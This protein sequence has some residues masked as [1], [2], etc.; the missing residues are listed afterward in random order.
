MLIKLLIVIVL[1]AIVASL[2]YSLFFMV[3]DERNSKK[4][5]RALTVR[6]ALSVTLFV[7]LLLAWYLGLIQPNAARPG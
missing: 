4:M 1:I 5:V 6:V 7:L 2:A 3:K